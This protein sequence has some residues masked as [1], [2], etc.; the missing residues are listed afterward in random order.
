MPQ[1][2]DGTVANY[3]KIIFYQYKTQQDIYSLSWENGDEKLCGRKKTHRKSVLQ[4][5]I[6]QVVMFSLCLGIS[7]ESKFVQ[8]FK[9]P[10]FICVCLLSLYYSLWFY[11][12]PMIVYFIFPQQVIF[13]SGMGCFASAKLILS[14]CVSLSNQ[15]SPFF[16][17]KSTGL[18]NW[19]R[20]CWL[21]LLSTR[22]NS[23]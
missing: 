12:F 6:S 20:Q 11:Q 14:L 21:C 8:N 15:A 4:M 3:I 2:Q 18:V 9:I 17:S 23:N 5:Q 13:V 22:L 16:F 10:V 19:S 7:N 1:V